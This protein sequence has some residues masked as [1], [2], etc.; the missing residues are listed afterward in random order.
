MKAA[1]TKCSYKLPGKF[2]MTSIPKMDQRQH[3]DWYRRAK[4]CKDAFRTSPYYLLPPIAFFSKI[5]F[6]QSNPAGPSRYFLPRCTPQAAGITTGM[7]L[8]QVS[9]LQ[10]CHFCRD[11]IT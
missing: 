4:N 2:S 3:T 7:S 5:F 9:F 10:G 11:I 1:E 8:L 6:R